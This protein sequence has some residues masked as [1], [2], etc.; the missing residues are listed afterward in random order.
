MFSITA[1]SI[2]VST[3]EKT[4]SSDKSNISIERKTEKEE[5]ETM[6]KNLMDKLKSLTV[7]ES[8]DDCISDLDSSDDDDDDEDCNCSEKS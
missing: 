1:G 3:E 6:H 5:S 8:L 7:K 2:S 4:E